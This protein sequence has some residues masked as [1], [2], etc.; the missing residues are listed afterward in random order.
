MNLLRDA[1][2]YVGKYFSIEYVRKIIL[3]QSEDDIARIDRE[4]MKEID[5]GQINTE[6]DQMDMYSESRENIDGTTEK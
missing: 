5:G 2:E 6:D 1:T 4:I 3:A